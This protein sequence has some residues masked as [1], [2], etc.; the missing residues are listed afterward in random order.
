MT[1]LMLLDALSPKFTEAQQVPKDDKRLKTSSLD[2]DS[3]KGS[4]RYRRSSRTAG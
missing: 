4:G 3:P 2:Y 1:S